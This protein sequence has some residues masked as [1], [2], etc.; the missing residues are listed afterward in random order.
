[1]RWSLRLVDAALSEMRD[2]GGKTGEESD[3]K[4]RRRRRDAK[5]I[6]VETSL[7]AV[8]Y[9]SFCGSLLPRPVYSEEWWKG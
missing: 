9:V 7:A 4:A 2:L 6:H 3:T 5:K 8:V 1:M